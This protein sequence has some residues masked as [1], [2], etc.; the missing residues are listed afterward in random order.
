MAEEHSLCSDE[1]V[2]IATE[3]GQLKELEGRGVR[4]LYIPEKLKNSVEGF[5]CTDF[6]CYPM[7][8]SISESMGKN[9]PVG[10]LGLLIDNE[11][12]ALSEF[13]SETYS[14]PRW[15]EIVSHSSCAVLDDLPELQPIVQTIDNFERNHKLGNLFE[16]NAGANKVLICTCRLQECMDL[17]EVNAY[18]RSLLN[19]IKSDRFAPRQNISAEALADL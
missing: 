6:W 12:P 2:V 17:P 11:H 7:F 18:A 19:Y 1:D 4:I 5:Y 13:P 14:T 8:R 3:P 9:V 15:Y 10:T 16:V